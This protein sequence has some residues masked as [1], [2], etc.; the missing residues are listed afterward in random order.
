MNAINTQ[1]ARDYSVRISHHK[2]DMY[3]FTGVQLG[4]GSSHRTSHIH[5]PGHRP[6]PFERCSGCRWTETVV[7]WSATD[8]KYV[9]HIQ[10]KSVLPGEETRIKTVWTDDPDVV[11]TSLLVVAPRKTGKNTMEL[12]QPNEDALS[13]A[14]ELDSKLDSAY[15]KWEDDN[16]DIAR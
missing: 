12:P 14:A 4:S 10:G 6:P 1:E 9:V 11:V 16:P 5:P 3:E 2:P 8:S 15:A 13:E 7:Y